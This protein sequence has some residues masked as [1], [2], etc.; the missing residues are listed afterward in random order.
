MESLGQELLSSKIV[1]IETPKVRQD[2]ATVYQS[3]VKAVQTAA[4][5]VLSMKTGPSKCNTLTLLCRNPNFS[6]LMQLMAAIFGL[7]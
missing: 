7:I 3:E 5:M 1:T 2:Q 6:L 4:E